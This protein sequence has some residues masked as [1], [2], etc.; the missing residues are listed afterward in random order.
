MER[1]LNVTI[2]YDAVEDT[3]R[4]QSKARGEA[5]GR[6][7]YEELTDIL[8]AQG[9]TV[10]RIAARDVVQLATELQQDDSDLIFNVCE[11]LNGVGKHE[12]N[13]AALLELFGKRFTGAGSIG[14]ALAGDKALAKK[15]LDFHGISTPRFSV[16]QS[17]QL[18]HVDDLTF[19]MFVKP[20]NEDASIGIDHRSIVHSFKELMERISYI[21]TEFSSPALIEEF[22]D[23]REIYAGVLLA[24]KPEALPLVE[25]DFSNVPEGTPKIASAEAKWDEQSPRYKNAPEVIVKDL[26]DAVVKAVQ[27]AA[28]EAV[29]ALKL[30]DYA[31]IDMRVRQRSSS[32]TPRQSTLPQD[33]QL[34][35]LEGWELYVIEVN[36]NPHLATNSELPLAAKAHGLAYPELIAR[37]VEIAMARPAA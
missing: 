24:Q 14:L 3:V 34:A 12:V 7:V 27:H 10:Q 25:W 29:K 22:I 32:T 13:V 11:S 23:G 30:R 36:P 33:P 1:K 9:H 5:S 15:L 19:P 21:E 35:A 37:L 8:S 31:R 17:G 2:L 28:I 6:L 16:M 26:P 4:E 20:S 18:E